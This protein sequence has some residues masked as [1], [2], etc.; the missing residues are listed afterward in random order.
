MKFL[1]GK[2]LMVLIASCGLAAAVLGVMVN[3]SGVFFTPIAEDLGVGR[4]AVSLTLTIS[5]LVFALGGMF[6]PKLVKSGN[7]KRM[8][9]LS[10]VVFAGSTALLSTASNLP[11]LYLFNAI[12]G[13]ASG[14]CGTVLL[15]IVINNWFYENTSLVTSI[16]MAFSGIA[17]AVFS[18]VL[19]SI[20]SS[21]GWRTAYLVNAGLVVLFELPAVLLP[22]GYFPQDAGCI[23]YGSRQTPP[24]DK[25]KASKAADKA[26]ISSDNSSA[27]TAFHFP[28]ILWILLTVFAILGSYVASYPPHFP[29]V[30]ESY[31]FT[32]AV[33]SVT[34]SICMA[35]NSGGKILFGALADRFGARNVIAI[36]INVIAV[37]GLLL[38][39]WRVPAGLY[40]GSA[41]FGLCYGIANLGVVTA[42][43]EL[44][45]REGYNV[46]YPRVSMLATIA[47]AAGS[48]LVGFMYDAA[49]S[50]DSGLI[51]SIALCLIMTVLILTIY[52]KK[53]ALDASSKAH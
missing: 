35:A 38:L 21:S 26:G 9:L 28:L 43:R 27:G 18:P 31:G 36:L 10:M 15:T 11:M 44:A 14:V 49:G 42:T 50:Y 53:K 30:A 7:F 19:A 39:L 37:G 45:G 51:L 24:A 6:T 29:G 40:I 25:A 48:S 13:L 3:V 23:P 34:L 52:A 4:G 17:G 20:I 22:I 32:A 47:N 12:R 46:V 41:L 33:G 5:N 2:Y 16:A 1:K 8:L